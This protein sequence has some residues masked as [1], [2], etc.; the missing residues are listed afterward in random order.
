MLRGIAGIFP[1]LDKIEHDYWRRYNERL[2]DFQTIYAG[3]D[4]DGIRTKHCQHAHVNVVEDSCN[5]KKK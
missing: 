2:T 4:I 5:T 3:Q 1:H